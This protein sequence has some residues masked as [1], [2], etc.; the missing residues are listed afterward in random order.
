MDDS[1]LNIPLD[2]G[3]EIVIRL[4]GF[5]PC[6]MLEFKKLIKLIEKETGWRYI[7]PTTKTLKAEI[8]A[9]LQTMVAYNGWLCQLNVKS[10]IAD[11]NRTERQIDI[12]GGLDMSKADE[13]VAINI[14]RKHTGQELIKIEGDDIMSVSK[15]KKTNILQEKKAG[16]TAKLA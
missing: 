12:L 8:K 11:R 5:F 3:G 4:D 9:Y 6:N 2:G 14:Y 13:I 7:E 15:T 10:A 1:R 16:P